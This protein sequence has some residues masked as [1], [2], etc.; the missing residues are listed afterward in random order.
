MIFFFL[1]LFSSFTL[2]KTAA[3]LCLP[4]A[5]L[6]I[7]VFTCCRSVE[8]SFLQNSS[9]LSGHTSFPFAAVVCIVEDTEHLWGGGYWLVF[10]YLSMNKSCRKPAK[11]QNPRGGSVLLPGQGCHP[12]AN[13]SGLLT[14]SS[15]CYS[16]GI[17]HNVRTALSSCRLLWGYKHQ[18]SWIAAEILFSI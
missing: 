2:R 5:Y 12:I 11:S 18:S 3:S 6:Q 4:A 7:R 15:L 14:L 10:F 17:P 9:L 16:C 13:C 8:G 1:F